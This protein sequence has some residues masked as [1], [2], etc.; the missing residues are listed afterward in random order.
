MQEGINIYIKGGGEGTNNKFHK[1]LGILFL[2]ALKM[3]YVQ[4]LRSFKGSFQIKHVTNNFK[5]ELL[6]NTPVLTNLVV[7]PYQHASVMYHL[8]NTF[9]FH[10]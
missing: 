2:T 6:I 10:V 5:P 9:R 7:Y 3:R 1:P 8:L 4:K